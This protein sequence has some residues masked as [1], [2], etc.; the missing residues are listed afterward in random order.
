MSRE[1]IRQKIADS[2]IIA[3][4]RVG[5]G[6]DLLRLVESYAK[7]GVTSIEITTNTPGC[8][9]A[10]ETIARTM[11]EIQIGV[12]TVR[13]TGEAGMAIQHGA[14]F[15]VTPILDPEIIEI[16]HKNDIPVCMGAFTPTEIYNAYRYGADM[17]KLFPAES[18]GIPYM[19][20]VLAPMP[21]MQMV[22]T[23]GINLQNAQDWFKA[24]ATALGVGSS[25]VH[26]A[27][28]ANK[29]YPALT[30]LAQQFAQLVPK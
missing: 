13:N 12:G 10:V 18:L 3:I 8:F 16:S 6:V 1:S 27:L 7:G 4:I 2:G 26:P 21:P 23:G 20:A 9:E 22:P 25:L 19:K 5:K 28:I 30:N 11:P 29:D 24:G 15:L 17:I 14:Q